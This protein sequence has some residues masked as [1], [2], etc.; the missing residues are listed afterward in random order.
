MLGSLPLWVGAEVVHRILALGRTRTASLS[1]RQ[2]PPPPAAP[3]A[4]EA[5]GVRPP[6]TWH[7]HSDSVHSLQPYRRFPLQLKPPEWE[8]SHFFLINSSYC[9]IASGRGKHPGKLK[10]LISTQVTACACR[11]LYATVQSV[12]YME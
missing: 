9:L 5:P 6:S 1:P 2:M 7:A 4:Q 12:K 3:S 10:S 11:A 8:I